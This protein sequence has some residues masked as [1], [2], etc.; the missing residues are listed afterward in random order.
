MSSDLLKEASNI[1]IE[2][3]KK[4]SNEKEIA[5]YIKKE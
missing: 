4:Y 2:N 5:F 1:I 3:L